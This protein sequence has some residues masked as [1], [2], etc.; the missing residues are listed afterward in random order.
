MRIQYGGSFDPIHNG[1][2][3]V[4]DAAAQVFASP[5]YL[6]PAAD[7]PHKPATGA[8]ARQRLQ[9][10]RLAIAGHAHLRVDVRELRRAGLSYSI[11]TARQLRSAL[12]VGEPLALLIGADSLLSLHKWKDWR[13]LLQLTHFIVAERPDNPLDTALDDELNAAISHRWV[14]DAQAMREVAAG[15]LYRLRL[16]LRPESSTAVR[17]KIAAGQDDWQ[18]LLPASV[19]AYICTHRLYGAACL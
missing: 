10:L 18:A 11:D 2:L 12:G 1:H 4:A 13:Q 16:P 8:T 9:I 5:V 7:P 14:D 6:M 19:A 17:Q 15:L 3:A